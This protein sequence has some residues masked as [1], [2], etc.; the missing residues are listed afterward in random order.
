MAQQTAVEW[1]ISKQKH[2]QIFDKETIEQTKE[3]HKADCIN[4]SI[5]WE[6]RRDEEDIKDKEDLY[7]SIYNK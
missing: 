4:F 6:N 1:L 7:N 2:N 3:M 5:E